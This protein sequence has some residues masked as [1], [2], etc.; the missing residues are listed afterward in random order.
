MQAW[1]CVL[2]FPCSSSKYFF[3]LDLVTM[4]AVTILVM[5][6]LRV[7]HEPERG[8]EVSSLYIY[9]LLVL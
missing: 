6:I 1:H 2:N 9:T 8:K 4:K 5:N 7:L 3:L